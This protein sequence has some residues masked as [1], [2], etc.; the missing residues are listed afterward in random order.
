MDHTVFSG[1]P[2]LA[3][4]AAGT[5]KPMEPNPPDVIRVL[6][7]WKEQNWAAHIWCW[8]TPVT[9]MDSPLVASD[10]C[11]RTN[12]GNSSSVSR[13]CNGGCSAR[14][15]STWCSQSRW[16]LGST[17]GSNW[18]R[19]YLRSPTTGAVTLTFLLISEASMSTCTILA[20][21]AKSLTLPVIR[22]SNRIPKEMSKS[23]WSMARLEEAMP[24]IPDIPRFR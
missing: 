6:G 17:S 21:G 8:P 19:T 5:S 13:I 9:T 4:R 22:S 1:R 23:A 20:L 3:P 24:C 2:T 11:F 14:N 16:T 10:N 18:S 15:E 7:S 12:W